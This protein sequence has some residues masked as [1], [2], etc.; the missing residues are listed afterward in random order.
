[1]VQLFSDPVLVVEIIDSVEEGWLL[2]RVR[3]IQVK[4][5]SLLVADRIGLGVIE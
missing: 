1:M 2:F 3:A 5:F 4:C